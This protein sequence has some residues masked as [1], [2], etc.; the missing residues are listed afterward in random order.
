VELKEPIHS[1]EYLAEE[2]L[3][4]TDSFQLTK[5]IF[6]VTR[7]NA[8]SNDV[9]LANFESNAYHQRMASPNSPEFLWNFTKREGDIRCLGHIINI[10]VQAILTQLKATP[11]NSTEAYRME[12]NATHIPLFQSQEEVVSTLSKL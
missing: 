4:I 10:G 5:A 1:R 3:K 7:D 11:S 2:L 9:M 8:S 6:T 12:P